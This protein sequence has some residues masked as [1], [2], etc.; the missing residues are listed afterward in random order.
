VSPRAAL[1]EDLHSARMQGEGSTL[2]LNKSEVLVT[3]L[4]AQL[5]QSSSACEELRSTVGSQQGNMAELQQQLGSL[6]DELAAAQ[7]ELQEAQEA[8]TQQVCAAGVLQR[9]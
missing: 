2:A 6:Q 5:A 4:K 7:K 8:K 9:C 3:D 1:Q